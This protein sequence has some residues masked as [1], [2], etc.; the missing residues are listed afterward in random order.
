VQDFVESAPPRLRHLVLPDWSFEQIEEIESL[1]ASQSLKTKVSVKS[2]ERLKLKT[3]SLA[4]AKE[5]VLDGDTIKVDIEDFGTLHGMQKNIRLRDIQAAENGAKAT[6]DAEKRMALLTKQFVAS[7]LAAKR[8]EVSHLEHYKYKGEY[9][10]EIWVDGLSL[11][12]VLLEMGYVVYYPF[13]FDGERPRPN[14][15]EIEARIHTTE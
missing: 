1:L 9:A 12:S 11:S 3:L 15:A 5:A 4:E 7:F 2:A 14:W 13:E 8:L 6:S 10:G